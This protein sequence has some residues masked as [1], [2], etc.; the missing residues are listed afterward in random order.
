MYGKNAFVRLELCKQVNSN[1]TGTPLCRTMCGKKGN[2]CVRLCVER[3]NIAAG[4]EGLA[5]VAILYTGVKD[6]ECGLILAQRRALFV[7]I[8]NSIDKGI[9]SFSVTAAPF[10]V[11]GLCL[12]HHWGLGWG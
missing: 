7:G 10:A 12:M 6:N 5:F 11:G 3:G 8:M 9:Q 4:C 2:E 1:A